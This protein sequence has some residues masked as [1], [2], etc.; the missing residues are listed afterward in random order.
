MRRKLGAA[1]AET[2]ARATEGKSG[3]DPSWRLS[4]ARAARD[5]LKLAL[6][7]QSLRIDRMGLS[8]VLELCPDRGLLGVL[9]GRGDALGVMMLAPDVLSGMIEAQTTGRVIPGPASARRPTRTD[10]AILAGM[11]DEALGN[12]E[13]AVAGTEDD[14]WAS[15]YRYA[16]FLEDARPLGLLLEDQPYRVL[17]A[18]VALAQG[19]KAGMIL[20][21]LPAEGTAPRLRR[22]ST[23]KPE[24]E[25]SGQFAA[26]FCDQVM[27]ADCQ[28]EA[29]LSRLSM[30]VSEVMNFEVGQML[31]LTG[32]GV[33]QIS[34]EGLDGRRIWQGRLGQNRGLRAV[35]LTEA[36]GG[37]E[38]LAA[39]MIANATPVSAHMD[40]AEGMGMGMAMPMGMPM[41][42]ESDGE[43]EGGFPAMGMAM[44]FPMA[45]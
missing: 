8:E 6:D 32:A 31:T 37:L 39:E 22:R 13:K 40:D 23:D 7:V 1:K 25:G 21:A 9:E 27:S 17:R 28:L 30:P 42:M 3:P 16:S 43:E 12:F 15:G 18:E 29:V 45:G 33:D 10:A 38:G 11:M 14:L 41:G 5:Q 20:L 44:D 19:A 26:E 36:Q 24:D 4:L 2:A 35:R 34:F